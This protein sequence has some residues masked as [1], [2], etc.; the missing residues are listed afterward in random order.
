MRCDCRRLFI[1]ATDPVDFRRPAPRRRMSAPRAARQH[2]QPPSSSASRSSVHHGQHLAP[3]QACCWRGRRQND[4]PSIGCRHRSTPFAP[5]GRRRCVADSDASGGRRAAW[6]LFEIISGAS[7]DSIRVHASNATIDA[8]AGNDVIDI[9]G[10]ANVVAGEGDD[11]V[12][13][14]WPF[15][16][17]RRRR[18]RSCPH[19]RSFNG[20]RR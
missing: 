10:Q 3:R 11:F 20:H 6:I 17:G 4:P 7:D 1:R 2:S 8:G 12:Q 15:D 14:L 13:H 5:A 9:E 18:R 16:R 19:V